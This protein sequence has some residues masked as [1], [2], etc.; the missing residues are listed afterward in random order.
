MRKQKL[1]RLSLLLSFSIAGFACNAPPIAEAEVSVSGLESRSPII[2]GAPASASQLFSTVAIATPFGQQ[3]CTGTLIASRVVLTAAHCIEN[4]PASQ[5]RVIAGTLRTSQ[6]TRPQFY[7]AVSATQHP[8]Y[9]GTGGFTI[10]PQGLSNR[11]DIAVIVVDRDVTQVPSAPLLTTD[12]FDDNLERGSPLI[13]TGYGVRVIDGRDSG[14]LFIAETPYVRRSASEFIA[15][16]SG[17][18]DTCQGDSGGPIYALLDG[19][20]FVVGATSRGIRG[21]RIK[22]G[23]GGIY[24][25]ASAFISFIE[26][27][28]GGRYSFSSQSVDDD[29]ST[30]SATSEGTCGMCDVSADC[31]GQDAVCLSYPDGVGFCSTSCDSDRD[32]AENFSCNEDRGF[33]APNVQQECVAGNVAR[34]DACGTTVSVEEECAR[35][36]D[37]GECVEA[38]GGDTCQSATSI[39]TETQIIDG[40]LSGFANNSQGECG[41]N[42]PERAYTF[43]LDEPKNFRAESIGFDTVLYLQ[44]GCGAELLC[45]DDKGSS[46]TDLGSLIEGSL[47]AGEYTLTIDAYNSEVGDFRF[48]VEFVDDD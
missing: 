21:T 28:S 3:F 8:S 7:S 12:Q 35:G 32:C 6:L 42:G 4:M 18:S 27:A 26:Q 40:T 30:P 5:I 17:F 44:R 15:G 23:A 13:I 19:K 16:G 10:D 31:E 39:S 46:R 1:L 11:A 14:T 34:V 43:T 24:S 48:R 22:C 20:A 29:A 2:D 33:C 41:G 45:N 37:D 25:M 9:R 36:C 47:D 38:L